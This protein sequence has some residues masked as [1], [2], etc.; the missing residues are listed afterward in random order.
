MPW[1]GHPGGHDTVRV[2]ESAGQVLGG[3]VGAAGPQDRVQRLVAKGSGARKVRGPPPGIQPRAVGGR[4]AAS[5]VPP[6]DDVDLLD[7]PGLVCRLGRGAGGV[8]LSRG[9]CQD[10]RRAQREEHRDG[11]AAQAPDKCTRPESHASSVATNS[12][13]HRC[14]AAQVRRPT[15]RS[16]RTADRQISSNHAATGPARKQDPGPAQSGQVSAAARFSSIAA[17]NSSV[18]R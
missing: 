4:Q 15:T 7:H 8:S 9:G 2:G 5:A 13:A 11:D 17:R 6:S 14:F 18:V 16:D 12:R 3:D 10:N 1:R